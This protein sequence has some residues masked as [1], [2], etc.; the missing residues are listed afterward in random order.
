MLTRL[1]FGGGKIIITVI[2]ISFITGIDAI[3]FYI[4]QGSRKKN[5]S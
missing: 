1:F 3:T 2:G 4:K 5:L